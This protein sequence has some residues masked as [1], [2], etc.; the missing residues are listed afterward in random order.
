MSMNRY[1]LVIFDWDGT[2]M[3]SVGKIVAC[4]QGMSRQL[5]QAVP[6]EEAIRDIIGLSLELAFRQL[7]PNCSDARYLEM[8]Q[9]YKA[10]YLEL[11]LTPSPLFDKA[12]VLLQTLRDRG[13]RLAVATGKRRAGL[14]RVLTE[15]SLGGYFAASRCADETLS[16]PHP[17]MLLDLLA[18]LDVAPSRALM[19]GDSLHDLNMANDAGIDAIGVSYGAHSAERLWQASPRAV[20]HEPMALLAHL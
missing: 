8:A 4:I 20:I 12:E 9:A 17:Q 5:C 15:T 2:L 16:K 18:H 13:Y 14:E 19:V 1:E 10:H 7:F 6:D 3:D 11:N